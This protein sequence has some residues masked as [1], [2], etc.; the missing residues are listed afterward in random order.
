MKRELKNLILRIRDQMENK[1]AK[2]KAATILQGLIY[3]HPEFKN[4]LP[5]T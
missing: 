5:P 4:F 3:L 1:E 2:A